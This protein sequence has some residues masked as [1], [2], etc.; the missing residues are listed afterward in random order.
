MQIANWHRLEQLSG[1]AGKGLYQGAAER[2]GEICYMSMHSLEENGGEG[3][4]EE[5]E[6]DLEGAQSI[7]LT[8]SACCSA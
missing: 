6:A 2:E 1:E 7:C 5:E 4:G 3:Q 8:T